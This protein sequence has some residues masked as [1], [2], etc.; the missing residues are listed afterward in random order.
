MSICICP[1]GFTWSFLSRHTD[2]IGLM[3]I[4]VFPE[5]DRFY[6]CTLFFAIPHSQIC[7]HQTNKQFIGKSNWTDMKLLWEFVTSQQKY[8]WF[9]YRVLPQGLDGD[10]IYSI[11]AVLSKNLENSCILKYIWLQGLHVTSNHDY[12]WCSLIINTVWSTNIKF[13]I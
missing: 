6:R 1:C 8:E 13:I 9:V 3:P 11:H 2:C 12:F 5:E 10:V 4:K 7:E